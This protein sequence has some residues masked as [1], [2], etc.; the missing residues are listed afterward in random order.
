MG[1]SPPRTTSRPWSSPAPAT[2]SPSRP[3]RRCWRRSRSS[4]PR[5]ARAEVACDEPLPEPL[6][7]ASSTLRDRVSRFWGGGL[8]VHVRL[9]HGRGYSIPTTKRRFLMGGSFKIG[10]FSGIDVRVHWTFFLLLAF[11]AFLGYQSSG[12]LAGALTP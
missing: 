11:F 2:G 5:T 7:R 8:C 3:P 9:I 10:R 6:P 4:W 12:S 1:S